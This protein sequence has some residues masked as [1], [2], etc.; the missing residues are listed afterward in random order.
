MRHGR[1]E[2][3]LVPDEAL[4]ARPPGAQAG[5]AAVLTLAGRSWLVLHVDWR[6]RIVQ[7][8]PTDGPRRGPLAGK[9]LWWSFAGW[10]ANLWL[11]AAANAACEK[12]SPTSTTWPSSL[13]PGTD[14]D[15]LR[16]AL[17]QADPAELALVPWITAEA[18]DGLK[19]SECL[20][21]QRA[22]ELVARRL[23]DSSSVAA[24]RQERL[25]SA[26]LAV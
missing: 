7:A 19:F 25:N 14:S 20:P 11:A 2:I 15:V 26:T 1:S 10:K 12:A 18:V 16:A 13:D 21:R 24:V 9:T 4:L 3:G 8:E 23:A 5:G 6:R 17:D 22:V